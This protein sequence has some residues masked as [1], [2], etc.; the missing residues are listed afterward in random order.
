MA[1]YLAHELVG[2]QGSRARAMPVD[3]WHTY[4]S[5]PTLAD[6]QQHAGARLELAPQ[7]LETHHAVHNWAD[8]M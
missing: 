7:A 4:L 8:G 6:P 1:Q 2:M 3:A 5:E